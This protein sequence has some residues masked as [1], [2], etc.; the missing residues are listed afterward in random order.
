VNPQ[1]ICLLRLSA[2]GDTCHIVPLL[3]AL[4]TAWP[5]AHITWVIGRAEARLMSLIPAVEFIIIDKRSLWRSA[6][7][8]RRALAGRR[9]DLLL[10]LQ[11]SLRASLYSAQIRAQ[12]KLGFDCA[13]ARELQW[14]FTD[15]GIA[16]GGNQHQLDAMLG[17]ATALGIAA[18]PLRW[19]F[20]LPA[21][22]RAWALE[23]IP[24]GCSA[25][26]ISPCASFAWRNWTA[27]SYAAVATYAARQHGMRVIICGSPTAMEQSMAAEIERLTELPV[28]N[29]VGKDTLPQ[30]LALIERARVLLAP[31]S[32]PAHM[33]TMVNTPVIGLYAATRTARTGPYRS[34]EWCIDRYAEAALRFR[35]RP[36]DTL[37]WHEDIRDAGVMELIEIAAVTA[38]LDELLAHQA[39]SHAT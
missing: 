20:P 12:Y 2:I 35:R 15:G 23:Q 22:A 27:A 13:R 29:L 5:A 6:R 18:S 31:D 24:D 8:L 34:R 25:L 33:A 37:G 30:L 16:P 14:L 19:D 38:K 26:V 39:G 3:R 9:F 32:G 17:F 1:S 36:A 11:T 28:V 7:H 21:A 4:Q 10:H